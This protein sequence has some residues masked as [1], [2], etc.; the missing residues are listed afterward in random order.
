MNKNNGFKET[1]LILVVSYISK[2]DDY[3]LDLENLEV[4]DTNSNKR[5]DIKELIEEVLTDPNY[6]ESFINKAFEYKAHVGH[7][8]RGV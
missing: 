5:L 6:V 4:I 3:S 8:I 1:M 2:S 7:K